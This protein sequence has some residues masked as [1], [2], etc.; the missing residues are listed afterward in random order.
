MMGCVCRVLHAR[1][2]LREWTAQ[3]LQMEVCVQ[4]VLRARTRLMEW[5]QAHTIRCV[6]PVAHAP[7]ASTVWDAAVHLP[8]LVWIVPMEPT[9]LSME[10]GT[11]HARP[12]LAVLRV[13]SVQD[14]LLLQQECVVHVPITTSKNPTRHGTISA[15]CAKDASRGTV[16]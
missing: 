1:Q 2:A 14:V 5:Q 10:A 9:S 16:A 8:E 3:A 12:V 6:P 11:L 15:P 13:W 4:R 7:Q